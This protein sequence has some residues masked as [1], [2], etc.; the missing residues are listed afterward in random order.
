MADI[1]REVF[2]VFQKLYKDMDDG[3][4]A[5]VVDAGVGP[6]KLCVEVTPDDG[7][8]LDDGPC[9]ALY[10]GSA[11]NLVIH[12]FAGNQVTFAAVPAGTLLPVRARRVMAT[13]TTA[14]DIVAVY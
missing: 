12:D 11:G 9:R 1:P 3:T 14:D 5:E 2:G 8:D 4:H 6:G 10:V 7:D 13:G